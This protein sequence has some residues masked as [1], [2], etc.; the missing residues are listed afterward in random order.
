MYP[1]ESADLL[2][3]MGKAVLIAVCVVLGIGFVTKLL[4][5][6]RAPPAGFAGGRATIGSDSESG[7]Q[8][9]PHGT[10]ASEPAWETYPP[11]T[12][13]RP[14]RQSYG[15]S[16]QT[17]TPSSSGVGAPR[18]LSGDTT[19][20]TD[21][22]TYNRV[23]DSAVYGDLT[24][25][26][27]EVRSGRAVLLPAGTE[28]NVIGSAGFLKTRVRVASGPYAGQEGVMDAGAVLP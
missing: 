13:P 24:A 12:N 28:V 17:Y 9:K 25:I 15:S 20:C 16:P 1:Q 11:Y 3:V 19:F 22:E 21:A 4:V 26:E 27:R 23:T 14:R 8:S 7:Q 2:Q 5:P 18:T 6:D 10:Q